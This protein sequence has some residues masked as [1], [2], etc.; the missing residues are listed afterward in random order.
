[1][2]NDRING[3]TKIYSNFIGKTELLVVRKKKDIG[4]EKERMSQSRMSL[5]IWSQKA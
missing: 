4:K 1:M 3:L 5:K 2:R